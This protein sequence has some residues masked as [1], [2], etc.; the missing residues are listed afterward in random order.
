MPRIKAQGIVE[1]PE[2]EIELSPVQRP[3]A[4]LE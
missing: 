3:A 2:G 4:F 1:L